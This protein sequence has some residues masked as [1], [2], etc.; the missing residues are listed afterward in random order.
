MSL[1]QTP[2]LFTPD[3]S[4][5]HTARR[6][7]SCPKEP[8][9]SNSS[10][11][12][13]KR[14]DERRTLAFDSSVESQ[15]EESVPR[16]RSSSRTHGSD[17]KAS[18]TRHHPKSSKNSTG[19]TKEKTNAKASPTRHSPRSST[20]ASHQKHRSS[21]S[22]SEERST[23]RSAS[24]SRLTRENRT[25]V[26]NSEV[27]SSTCSSASEEEETLSKPKHLLK[28]P[29]F[30]G[31]SSFET[32]WAQFTNCAEHNKWSKQ[33]KLVYL[34]SSLDKDVTNILW[35]YDKEKISSLS[36]LT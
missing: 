29:K 18:P 23:S 28:P 10:T 17:A 19:R 15:E 33:Q 9:T 35:D 25:H 14:T 11:R 34:K 2:E 31:Q 5:Y 22:R 36:G 32:F 1:N 30:D 20:R 16:R 3:E 12:A 8:P 7:S 6:A 13:N 27:T 4:A 26:S 24:R 21:S